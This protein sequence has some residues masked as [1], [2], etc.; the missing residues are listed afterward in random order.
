MSAVK[1][2]GVVYDLTARGNARQK[3]YFSE[4]RAVRPKLEKS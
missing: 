1:F 3:I 4:L 2:S